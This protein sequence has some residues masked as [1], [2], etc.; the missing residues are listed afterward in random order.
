MVFKTKLRTLKRKDGSIK[1]CAYQHCPDPELKVGEVC[2]R[3][4]QKNGGSK[5]FHLKCWEKMHL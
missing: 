4:Q 5:F 3:K 1:T 2:I